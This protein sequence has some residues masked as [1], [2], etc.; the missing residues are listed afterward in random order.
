MLQVTKRFFGNRA[1]YR[2]VLLTTVPIV[3]QNSISN[4]ISLLDNLMVGSVGTEQM[5]GV[6][7]VNKLVFVLFLCIFG[8]VSGPGLFTAQFYGK[9]DEEGIRHT[10]RFKLLMSLALGAIALVIFSLGGESLIRLYIH[11]ESADC[12]PALTLHYAKAYLSVILLGILPMALTPVYSSTLRECGKTLPPMVASLIGV[13]TNLC[14]NSVLIFGLLGMP[15]LGAVGAAIA[16]VVA[17]YV[18]CIILIVWTHT[19]R[20]RC[21]YIK[22][23][24][25]SLRIPLPLVRRMFL[26][27]IPLLLNETLWAMGMAALLQ[28]YSIRGTEVVSAMNISN[29]LNDT[30]AVLYISI[31]TA[32]SILV[33]Q[34]L[35]AGD[36]EG[37]RDCA[38]KLITLSLLT[39]I[40]AGLLLLLF[41]PIFP[42]LYNTSPEIRALAT[43]FTLVVAASSPLHAFLNASYFTLRSGGKTGITFL[44]DA[45]YIWA[46]SFT[47]A[48]LLM[49][50]T[51]LTAVMAYFICQMVDLFKCILGGVLVGRGIWVK[52]IVSQE[53]KPSPAAVAGPTNDA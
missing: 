36:A 53:G 29:M 42:H 1:F 21:P 12:D 34:R 11:G 15:A 13:G 28:C 46:V 26:T 38:R 27:G 44:F 9:R 40:V 16:T 45:G 7:I 31:G 37:A 30:F 8:A 3:V 43:R 17:R 48:F 6:A 19:H 33:G 20:E 14:L 25:R 10:F 39:G 22:G 5:T 24:Y 23:I 2:T 47:L 35:G 52:D 18:E 50:L 41:A 49:N 4:F 32:I 51:S